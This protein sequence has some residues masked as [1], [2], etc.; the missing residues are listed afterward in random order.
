MSVQIPNL[1]RK[2][3]YFWNCDT[4]GNPTNTEGS[5]MGIVAMNGGVSDDYFVYVR[6]NNRSTGSSVQQ[7]MIA[8][9]TMNETIA[10]TSWVTV[11]PRQTA[12]GHTQADYYGPG[13]GFMD[14]DGH[15]VLGFTV[16]FGTSFVWCCRGFRILNRAATETT[17]KRKPDAKV[18]FCLRCCA[19]RRFEWQRAERWYYQAERNGW[20]CCVAERMGATSGAIHH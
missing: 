19:C 4:S 16:A 9:V 13:M 5:A 10:S 11:I 6:Y 15:L 14:N 7:M 17:A 8:R 3:G 2:F 18:V 1:T 20:I 12:L